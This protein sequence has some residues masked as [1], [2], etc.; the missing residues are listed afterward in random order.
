MLQSQPKIPE[1][2]SEFPTV[3]S[4]KEAAQ[5]GAKAAGFAFSVSSS[6]MT[7]R[8]KVAIRLLLLCSVQWE[9]N[10][11]ITM[12]LQKKPEKESNQ[13]N[14]KA[15]VWVVRSSKNQHNHELL[16]ES[17]VHCLYQHRILNPEQKEIVHMM[18]KSGVPVQSVADT[19]YW[20]HE[21]V[22]TK[23][24]VNE[25]DRIKNALNEGS[26]RDMTMHLIQMLEELFVSDRSQA[27]RKAANIVFP[28][29]KK[30]VCIWH[31]LVQ[32]LK[33]ACRKFFDNEDDYN[34]LLLSIQ[35]VAYAEEMS[36]V[37]KAFDKK[38]DE[39]C[40]M[41]IFTKYYPHM[42]VHSIQRAEGS[43][44]CL[45]K[46]IEAATFGLNIV[47]VDLFILNNKRFEQLVGKILKWA[48]DQI[49]REIWPIPLSIIHSRW[50]LKH[51]S[52]SILPSSLSPNIAINKALYMLEEKYR[53]LNDCGS[54]ATL[55]NKIN[56]L[57]DEE[58][59]DPLLSERQD[60]AAKKKEKNTPK[61]IKDLQKSHQPQQPLYHDQIPI[62][63]HEHIKKIINV[64]RDGNCGYRAL[65]VCLGKS[66]SKWS[67]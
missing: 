56:T 46:A 40:W 7:R 64:D 57:I 49:K 25:R 18:L 53:S 35:K 27:L 30:M 51:D 38:K 1:I 13:Q 33:T 58:I 63:M 21:T 17:Q 52:I 20:K 65:A 4:F 32:N 23:D 42:G 36:I 41:N 55:L 26:N 24:I 61:L 14:E 29:A 9:A 43:Y 6:K 54:K 37:E 67:E 28:D 16:S 66:E 19:I 22:Y 3:E 2:G 39:K 5:E 60:K 44:S 11:E 12:K 47:S 10:I 34:K 45:K 8:K 48:I 15:G 62:Y 31:M 59:R 50:L